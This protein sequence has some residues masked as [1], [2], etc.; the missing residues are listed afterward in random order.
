MAMNTTEFAPESPDRTEYRFEIDALRPE[1]LSFSRL[2][3][4]L[5]ELAK[6]YGDEPGLHFDRVASGSAVL[7]A[8]AEQ[9]ARLKVDDRIARIRTGDSPPEALKAYQKLNELLRDDNAVGMIRSAD[10]EIIGFPGR[11]MPRVEEIGPVQQPTT[12]EGQLIRIGGKDKTVPFLLVDGNRMW[13]GNT[14]RQLAR[15][16]GQHLFGSSLRVSG[17]GTW[18]RRS[19]GE[20]ELTRFNA[21]AF[22]VLDDAS[23]P[24]ALAKLRALGGSR[25]SDEK[26]PMKTWLE[27][28][29]DDE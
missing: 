4:Y 25:W 2:A 11:K 6:V 21:A 15:E 16:L 8:W 12:I 28:R 10:A 9:P 19:S 22:E 7:I 14:T 17:A 13:N 3:A 29:S 1:T 23:L 18:T 26:D 5:T 24:E 20:W 27:L